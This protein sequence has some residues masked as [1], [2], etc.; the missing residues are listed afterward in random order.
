MEWP[1]HTPTP[2]PT[3]TAATHRKIRVPSQRLQVPRMLNIGFLQANSLPTGS[4][5]RCF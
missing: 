3:A 2:I 1:A 5:F 4:E